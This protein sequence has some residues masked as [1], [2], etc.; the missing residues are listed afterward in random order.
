MIVDVAEV[1]A[2]F[3]ANGGTR[4]PDRFDT[5]SRSGAT[6]CLIVMSRLFNS[7]NASMFARGEPSAEKIRSSMR[8][9]SLSRLS[10]MGK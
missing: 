1:F 9:S 4:A 10:R 8:S 3:S 7:Y 6:A 2:D 5:A